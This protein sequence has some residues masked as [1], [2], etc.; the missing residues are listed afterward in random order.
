MSKGIKRNKETSDEEILSD[1]KVEE[2][3]TTVN[4]PMK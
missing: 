4:Y 1:Q 2:S 3:Y